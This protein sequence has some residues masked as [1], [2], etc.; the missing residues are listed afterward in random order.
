MLNSKSNR[1]TISREKTIS[2]ICLAAGLA[3]C[4]KLDLTPPSEPSTGGF[5]SNQTELE[6]AVNDLY[7]LPFWGNDN[8]L[9]TDNDW[10]RAQLTNAVIGGT[11]DA[12]NTD[13]QTYWLNAYKAIAR[14]N[15]YRPTCTALPPLRLQIS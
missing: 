15:S 9:H 13:V 14:A 4:A 11:M 10:H 2:I 1:K 6:L 3:S 12:E 5:Y 7:R 8:E